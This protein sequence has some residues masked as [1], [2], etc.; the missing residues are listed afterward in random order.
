MFV[1][2]NCRV[3]ELSDVTALQCASKN[4]TALACYNFHVRRPST[5]VFLRHSVQVWVIQNSYWNI[6]PIVLA[7][8]GWL[9]GTAVERR[10][11]AGELSLSCARPAADGWPLKWV[12]R[13]LQ[14]NQPGQLSLSSFWVDKWV[15][16]CIWMSAT[17]VR[18]GAIW[19]TLTKERQAWCNL[20]VK[21]Y[22]AC[23]SV[24][25]TMR[26]M[27]GVM[28][29]Y[30]YSSFYFLYLMHW[31]NDINTGHNEKPQ[32]DWTKKR[33]VMTKP[34]RKWLTFCR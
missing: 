8:F 12:N 16:G 1:C 32:N 2:K 22:S 14:I 34:L 15:V 28:A 30:K 29:L 11:L 23:L 10:S 3:P 27:N 9:R 6:R 19:W 21:L 33:D 26:S 7:S 4:D 25:E 20:Q 17:S 5:V 24:L 31:R 13:P 18:G